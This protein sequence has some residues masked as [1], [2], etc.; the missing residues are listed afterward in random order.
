MVA[1][2]RLASLFW[3]SCGQVEQKLDFE[4]RLV[5][6]AFVLGF[7]LAQVLVNRN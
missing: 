3:Y 7:A 6:G 2:F 5:N 1:I 4:T